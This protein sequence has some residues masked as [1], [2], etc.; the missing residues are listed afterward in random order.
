MRRRHLLAA[1]IGFSGCVFATACLSPT[2]PLPPPE[3]PDS[4]AMSQPGL[5][6]VRGS[7][8][9]GARVLITLEDG[10]ITGRE[11]TDN[12]GRY[13]IQIQAELC[14]GAEVTE[15]VGGKAS[16]ATFFVVEPV[17]NGM[18]DDSCPE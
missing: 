4:I 10:T 6:D 7:C 14:E 1:A 17:T 18:G 8:T 12:D 11:D 5:W 15:V 9:P 3:A 16:D 2:L 13:F